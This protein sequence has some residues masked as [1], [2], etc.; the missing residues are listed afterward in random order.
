M[1]AYNLVGQSVF[2]LL[3]NDDGSYSIRQEHAANPSRIARV[4]MLPMKPKRKIGATP[5]YAADR[6][7]CLEQRVVGI[8]DDLLIDVDRIVSAEVAEVIEEFRTAAPPGRYLTPIDIVLR[9]QI[10]GLP[11]C[12]PGIFCLGLK[13]VQWKGEDAK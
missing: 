13:E 3:Q 2:L 11:V 4:K 9:P 6:Y 8:D 10:C 5:V 1:L 12:P 7:T